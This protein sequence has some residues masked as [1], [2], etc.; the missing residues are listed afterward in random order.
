[1]ESLGGALQKNQEHSVQAT[2]TDGPSLGLESAVFRVG[3]VP[4]VSDGH[5][6]G[7]QAEQ[8]GIQW[9]SG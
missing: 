8:K 9:N 4:N 7:A 3:L 5:I 1:M 6:C 2:D